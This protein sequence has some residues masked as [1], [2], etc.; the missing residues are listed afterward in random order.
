MMQP[1]SDSQLCNDFPHLLTRGLSY[2]ALSLKLS[3]CEGVSDFVN[4]R[5][6]SL[7][8]TADCK[9]PYGPSLSFMVFTEGASPLAGEVLGC[10]AII[11]SKYLPK[12]LMVPLSQTQT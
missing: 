1:S 10:S 4:T 8:T 6:N 9:R 3:R 11:I 7:D 5:R 2:E 12:R